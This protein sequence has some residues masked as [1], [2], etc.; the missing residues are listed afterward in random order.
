MPLG[1]AGQKIQMFLEKE[2]AYLLNRCYNLHKAFPLV[3]CGRSHFHY[4][5]WGYAFFFVFFQ[6]CSFIGSYKKGVIKYRERLHEKIRKE[7]PVLLSRL[8]MEY[9]IPEEIKAP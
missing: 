9:H 7:L 6:I 2:F 3:F 1:D 5:T 8:G 4:N